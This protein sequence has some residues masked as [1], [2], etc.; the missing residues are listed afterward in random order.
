MLV[1]VTKLKMKTSN[2]LHS[3]MLNCWMELRAA[4]KKL[5]SDLQSTLEC[6]VCLDTIR[7]VPVQ[8]CSN[9]HIICN[10]CRPR[11]VTCPT[12]RDPLG[13]GV[14]F[15]A[16]KL[17]DLIPHPCTNKQRGCEEEGMLPVLTQHETECKY[18]DVR[19]PYNTIQYNTIVVERNCQCKNLEHT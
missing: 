1:E 4:N 10:K 19:C 17:I 13:N 11:S 7:T 18:R 8:C 12:C 14:S 2:L 5:I 15:I 6:P 3:M 16:N 9:G